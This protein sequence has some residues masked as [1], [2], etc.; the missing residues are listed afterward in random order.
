MPMIAGKRSADN[1]HY[2]KKGHVWW[3]NRDFNAQREDRGEH[4]EWKIR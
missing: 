1:R 3:P 2:Q 4:D